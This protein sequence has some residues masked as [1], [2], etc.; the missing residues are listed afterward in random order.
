MNVKIDMNH[1]L[2]LDGWR[3]FQSRFDARSAKEE[4]VLQVN[5]DPGLSVTYPACVVL[6]LGLVIVFTQKKHY[7]KAMGKRLRADAT[8]MRQTHCELVGTTFDRN[9]RC[10]YE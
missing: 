10:A 6:L 4:T 1:P 8:T 2:R 5:R 9:W 3:L 7:L